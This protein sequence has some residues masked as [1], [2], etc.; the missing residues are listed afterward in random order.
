[1]TVIA[2]RGRVAGNVRRA[3]VVTLAAVTAGLL[4][5]CGGDPTAP[6]STATTM[7]PPPSGPAPSTPSPSPSAVAPLTGL[8]AAEDLDHAAVVVKVSDVRQAHP[9]VGVEDADL[10]FVEPIGPAYTRLAAVFHSVLPDAVGPVR[11]ARPV[12]AP[13]LSP[14]RPVLGSTMAAEWVVRYLDD[15][16]DLD[17]RGSLR[18]RGVYEVDRSRPAPDH[19][20]VPPAALLE[21]SQRDEAPAPY[22]RRA[23]DVAGSSAVEGG[24]AGSSVEVSY[25]GQWRVAW[26]WAEA[27]GRYERSAP[28]GPHV[29][30][31]GDRVQA[32]NVLV[33]G[34]ESRVEKL[35]PGSGAPVPVPRLVDATGPLVALSG[36]HAVTGTWR[37]GGIRDPF[38]LTTDDGSPLL[39]APGRTWVEM[40]PDDRAVVVR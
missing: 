3:V 5:A 35:G 8:P 7:S 15:N 24:G 20:L 13:L 19:V 33:L 1:M 30:A 26:T 21:H 18:V 40:P 11:S 37:K 12:D 34:V 14:L 32:E 9:Q 29:T 16:G 36:G 23:E 4:A 10:V 22:F 17:H 39:L 2:R 31:D 6:V 28:W 25:G 38:E 27:R